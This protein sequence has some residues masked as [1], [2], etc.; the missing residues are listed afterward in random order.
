MAIINRPMPASVLR[1]TSQKSNSH[2]FVDKAEAM[3]V[4]EFAKA[5][6]RSN[7]NAS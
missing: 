5:R 1:Q 7:Q 6:I 4:D 3:S 2:D